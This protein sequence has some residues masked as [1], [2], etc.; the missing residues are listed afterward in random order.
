VDTISFHDFRLEPDEQRLWSGSAVVE[1]RPRTFAVLVNLVERAGKLVRNDELLDAVW[2][3][4]A[5]TPGTL[6]T[7]IRELRKALQ[8]D[9]RRPRFIETVHRRG[10]RFIAPVLVDDEEEPGVVQAVPTSP[11]LVATATASGGLHGREDGL[12]V[13]EARLADA[14]QGERQVVFVTGEIGIGKTSLLRSFIERHEQEVGAGQLLWARGQS[15]HQ[16]GEGEAYHPVLDA[17]ERLVRTNG[18]QR[19]PDLMKRYAPTWALQ[20]P[21]LFEP[22][23]L[24]ELRETVQDVSAARMLREF[25]LFIEALT[26]EQPLILWLEDMHWSDSATLDLVGALA[27]RSDPAGLVVVA[28]YRPFDAAAGM[29]PVTSLHRRLRQERAAHE[30]SLPPLSEVDVS[31]YLR[32]RFAWSLPPAGLAAFIHEQT[33]GNPLLMVSLASHLV[34]KQML[35]RVGERWSLAVSPEAMA[36]SAPEGLGEI[37]DEQL[38]SLGRDERE[39]LEVGSAIGESF[40]VPSL[41]AALEVDD[42]RADETCQRLV[43]MGQFIGESDAG[44]WPDGT[45]A[46]RFDFQHAAFRRILY[47]RLAPARRRQLHLRIAERVEAGFASDPDAQAVFLA[48]HYE[49]SGDVPRAVAYLA[50]AASIAGR[51]FQQREAASYSRRAIGLLVGTA[52]GGAGESGEKELLLNLGRSLAALGLRPADPEYLNTCLRL[53]RELRGVQPASQPGSSE[54][55]HDS[56]ALA[57]AIDRLPHVQ[58]EAVRLRYLSGLSCSEIARVTVTPR[59]TVASRLVSGLSQLNAF[60]QK[61]SEVLP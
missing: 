30:V 25:C 10:F 16:H 14:K 46:R 53:S 36:V 12:A 22:D 26:R 4:A 7:S 8:D 2:G 29:H 9:A 41:A 15:V 59:P 17:L 45:V 3:D 39:A 11:I 32:E 42:E 24:L 48:T 54:L 35:C 49:R 31:S 47:G 60:L 27:R 58:K 51:R 57:A 50:R 23:A 43:Q 34:S 61:H 19:F 5:V 1:L 55:E 18:P 13:M 21:W 44:R 52:N 38:E 33:D 56:V 37:V 20:L 6:N 28:T 40:T